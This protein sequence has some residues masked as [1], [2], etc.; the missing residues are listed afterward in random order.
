MMCFLMAFCLLFTGCSVSGFLQPDKKDIVGANLFWTEA[1]IE[2]ALDLKLMSNTETVLYYQSSVIAYQD[3]AVWDGK[4][5]VYFGGMYFEQQCHTVCSSTSSRK[6][7]RD[8][9]AVSDNSSPAILMQEWLE[10]A[11]LRG[12]LLTRVVTPAEYS[13]YLADFTDPAYRITWTEDAPNW[14]AM[15]DAH[16]DTLFGG[17]ELL[18]GFSSIKVTMFF[19][20]ED[21]VLDVV[22]LTVDGGEEG[23]L[24]FSIA[25]S[26][27]NIS[28]NIDYNGELEYNVLL[29]EEWEMISSVIED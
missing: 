13:D 20:I 1:P 11:E 19:G 10:E 28:P 23:W 22:L 21:L 9:C 18:E 25:P 6:Q 27:S 15:C 29:G 3:D 2:L 14:K 17:A 5:K 24:N 4:A 16:P 12:T 8:T 7:W 26:T